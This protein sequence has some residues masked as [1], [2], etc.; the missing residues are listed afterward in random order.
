[1]KNCVLTILL[2]LFICN[3]VY[4]KTY[5]V[6]RTIKGVIQNGLMN[7][8]ANGRDSAETHRL[9][10]NVP[11][12]GIV[13]GKDFRIAFVGVGYK[14]KK[15]SYEVLQGTTNYALVLKFAE[16]ALHQ[17]YGLQTIA[18]GAAVN[19]YTNSFWQNNNGFY[20]NT[21]N[22]GSI[23]TVTTQGLSVTLNV[24]KFTVSA[25]SNNERT[26]L[27]KQTKSAN[28][29]E[30]LANQ[31][32]SLNNHKRVYT[33]SFNEPQPKSRNLLLDNFTETMLV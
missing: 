5:D 6:N 24:H 33:I 23:S 13:S 20:A 11:N 18:N 22:F 14:K 19:F 10:K 16:D 1:M 4:S 28:I 9:V 3:V 8:Q 2:S 7:F 15:G 32:L 29:K 31:K 25:C 12:A 17:Y 26:R 27:L 30:H 21:L